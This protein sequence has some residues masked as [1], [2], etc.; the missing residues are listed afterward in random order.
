MFNFIVNVD[1]IVVLL[2]LHTETGDGLYLTI[3]CSMYDGQI[4]ETTKGNS[5]I[6]PVRGTIYAPGPDP[7]GTNYKLFKQR[8]VS[9]CFVTRTRAHASPH[10]RAHARTR[11]RTHTCA[12][13]HNHWSS[14]RY[15]NVSPSQFITVSRV[16]RHFAL[17]MILQQ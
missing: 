5:I 6:Q 7:Q 9:S 13:P 2:D 15:L 10:A 1:S 12:H 3:C 4:N 8:V 17:M 11:V 16:A 14:P